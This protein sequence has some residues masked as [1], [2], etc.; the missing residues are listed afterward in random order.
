[1]A[2]V[3]LDL[4]D[5]IAARL[6]ALP[7]QERGEFTA[8]ALD[9]AFRGESSASQNIGDDA[10]DVPTGW[11]MSLDADERT[12]HREATLSSLRAIDS[13]RLSGS[14]EMLERV[15]TTAETGI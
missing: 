14:A 4:P 11:W 9:M 2:T 6:T 12:A 8:A 7:E 10:G 15:R 3:T 13:G 1:M 5:H